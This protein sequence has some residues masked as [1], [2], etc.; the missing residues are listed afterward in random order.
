LLELRRRRFGNT[1]RQTRLD[2]C[3]SRR[4]AADSLLPDDN[5]DHVK[6]T[7]LFVT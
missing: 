3:G 1:A 6:V 5:G 4:Q 2:S 7:R